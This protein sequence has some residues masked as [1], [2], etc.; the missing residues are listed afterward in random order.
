MRLAVLDDPVFDVDLYP[1]DDIDLPL[2]LGLKGKLANLPEPLYRIRSHPRLDDAGEDPRDG[3][4]DV[5]GPAEG[6]SRVRLPGDAR[7]HRLERRPVGHDVRHARFVAVLAVQQDA[8][9]TMSGPRRRSRTTTRIRT[10]STQIATSRRACRTASERS[11]AMS[12]SSGRAGGSTSSSTAHRPRIFITC[13]HFLYRKQLDFELLQS[14]RRQ[15]GLVLLT[16][17]DF[18]SSPFPQRRINEAP[19]M[20]DD[21]EAKRLIKAGL[22]GDH[23]FHAVV[24]G[25]PRM[26]GFAAFAG[27]GYETVPLAADPEAMRPEPDPT[28]RGRYL[29]HRGEPPHEAP[30]DRRVAP[31]AWPA[32]RL[33]GLRPGLDAPRARGRLRREGRAVLQRPGRQEPAEAGAPTR[34]RGPRLRELEGA[35]Q[36]P[37]RPPAQ[38]RGRLQRADIQ[39]P[40]LRRAR[41]LRR[42]RVRPRLLRR[43]RGDRDRDVARRLVRQDRLLP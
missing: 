18:W 16:K 24:Q 27:Q 38:V 20:K 42:R 35:R 5:R 11:V 28:L 15:H 7:R 14:W 9:N 30:G 22:L 12:S 34:R 33:E 39:D 19:S 32:L 31:A 37:R 43:R 21:A 41:D 29:V 2:R 40:V 17:I 36:P 23:Y 8:A 25:D 3:E 6:R 4:E 26:E 1:A 13:S 10:A